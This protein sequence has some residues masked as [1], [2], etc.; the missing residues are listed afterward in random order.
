[1]APSVI[2]NIRFL[3]NVF[4]CPLVIGFC[5][6]I[7][8]G[9]LSVWSIKFVGSHLNNLI[10]M[11]YIWM[12][13][14]LFILKVLVVL[15]IDC[16]FNR[17]ILDVF[18]RPL[19]IGLSGTKVLIKLSIDYLLLALILSSLIAWFS[20]LSSNFKYKPLL[21]KWSYFNLMEFIWFYNCFI[22]IAFICLIYFQPPSYWVNSSIKAFFIFSL[23]DWPDK[24]KLKKLPFI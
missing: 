7:V 1:M 24:L 21:I 18:Y 22:L 6:A 2:L 17:F 12:L 8:F 19:V 11:V 13:F 9:A 5:D 14:I 4:L 20:L 16:L 10:K 23:F 15:S 3:V